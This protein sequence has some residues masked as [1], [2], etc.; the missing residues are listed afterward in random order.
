MDKKNLRT[1]KMT[2]TAQTLWH[3]EHEAAMAGYGLKKLGKVVDKWSRTK[4]AE[5]AERNNYGKR[6]SKVD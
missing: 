1:I 2:V 4:R 6:R 5:A 3:L